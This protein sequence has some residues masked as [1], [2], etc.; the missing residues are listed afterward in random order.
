MERRYRE[1]ESN[2]VRKSWPNTS[3]T[4]PAPVAVAA[5]CGKEARNVFIQ[6]NRNLPAIAEQSIADALSLL[7][8]GWNLSGQ[9]RR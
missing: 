3:P 8:K 6:D 1:T 9:R 4:S 2:A 7:Q 5:D